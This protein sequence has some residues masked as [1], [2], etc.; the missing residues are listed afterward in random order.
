M[1]SL[2]EYCTIWPTAGGQQYY[3]QAVATGRLRPILSYLV[4]WAVIVGEISTG[5]SCALNS[6]Q[7]IASLVE[8]TYPDVVWKVSI[9]VPASSINPRYLD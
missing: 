6:A 1:V 7:I 3:T 5:S 2:A 9:D 4:G 8:V